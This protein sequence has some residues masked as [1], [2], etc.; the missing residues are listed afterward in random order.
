MSY[1]EYQTAVDEATARA[2][3]KKGI[4]HVFSAV[5]SRQETRFEI[6]SLD[7][8]PRWERLSRMQA[9]GEAEH[10]VD[11]DAEDYPNGPVHVLKPGQRT[12]KPEK[13]EGFSLCQADVDYYGKPLEVGAMYSVFQTNDSAGGG[14]L[15]YWTGKVFVEADSVWEEGA[16]LK[17]VD[18]ETEFGRGV[19]EYACPQNAPRIKDLSRIG[20]EA[21]PAPKG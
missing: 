20:V 10:L 2:K 8:K 18:T 5:N 7:D 1:Y 16:E 15:A 3:E 9:M 12:P 11:V 6:C 21:A 4:Y 17:E 14:I 19:Y 13:T